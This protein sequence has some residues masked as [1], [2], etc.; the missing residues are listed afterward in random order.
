MNTELLGKRALRYS[1]LLILGADGSHLVPSKSAVPVVT[2][3]RHALRVEM[4]AVAVAPSHAAF[5]NCIRR[6]VFVRAKK[7]MSRVDTVPNIAAMQDAQ[8]FGNRTMRQF[9]SDLVGVATP[10][11]PV[12]TALLSGSP[13]PAAALVASFIHVVPK[14]FDVFRGKI[15]THRSY[16][17]GVAP[18][19]VCA[20]ARHSYIPLILPLFRG[21]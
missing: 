15:L 14:T 18:G 17:F 21:F 2:A 10:K 4:R 16:S 5:S 20:V 7:E 8:S 3:T 12:S 13:Q 6:I 1:A 19:A 11:R 9:P